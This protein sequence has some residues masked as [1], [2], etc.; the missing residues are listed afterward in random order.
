MS[1]AGLPALYTLDITT[2]LC[3]VGAGVRKN[4]SHTPPLAKHR[5]QRNK[6]RN[7]CIIAKKCF[8][9]FEQLQAPQGGTKFLFCI[10]APSTRLLCYTLV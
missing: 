9:T 2:E 8:N 3:Y 4:H 1:R 10:I 7:C 6:T 5:G